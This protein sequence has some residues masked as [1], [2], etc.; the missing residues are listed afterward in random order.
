MPLWMLLEEATLDVVIHFVILVLFFFLQQYMVNFIW[1]KQVRLSNMLFYGFVLKCW[2]S[3]RLIMQSDIPKVLSLAKIPCDGKIIILY[4]S[5]YFCPR[6]FIYF[7]WN[8]NIT[9][10]ADLILILLFCWKIAILCL[11]EITEI[12]YY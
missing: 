4:P 2:S 12:A 8:F 11:R 1:I 9:F 6:F 5:Y 7:A 3:D 10:I